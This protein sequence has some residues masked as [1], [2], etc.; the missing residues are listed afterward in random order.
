MTK[1][2]CDMCGKEFGVFDLQNSFSFHKH[3]GY[4]SVFDLSRINI[5]LC[6]ECFDKTMNQ[7]IIP[8]CKHNV[9]QEV[10]F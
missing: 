6:C 3:V 10:E 4:G 2:V 5:D 8:N 7:Y 9:V 1:T